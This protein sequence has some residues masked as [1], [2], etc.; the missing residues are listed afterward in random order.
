MRYEVEKRFEIDNGWFYGSFVLCLKRVYF[1][2]D[3]SLFRDI[4]A[5]LNGGIRDRVYSGY[6]FSSEHGLLHFAFLTNQ[7]EGYQS[8]H[9]LKWF[10]YHECR[11]F[12]RRYV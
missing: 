8:H 2:C 4:L 3:Q 11:K 7:L 5:F 12:D 9:R 10:D 6:S 1:P